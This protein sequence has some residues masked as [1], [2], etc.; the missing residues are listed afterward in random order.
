MTTTVDP[1]TEV[2]APV[3]SSGLST[4]AVVNI[5]TAIA[6]ALFW[7]VSTS[8]HPWNLFARAG[9]S[10]DFYDEQARVFLR[11]RLAVD[12]AVPGPEGFL[13]DGGTY[14]YYGPFLSIVRMPFQ[15]FGDL[16]TARLVRVSMLIA[17]VVSCRWSARLARAA[18]TVVTGEVGSFRPRPQTNRS[19]RPRPQTNRTQVPVKLAGRR[20]R[21]D[22]T[23][24]RWSSLLKHAA[25][26]AV[27]RSMCS[28]IGAVRP[29]YTSDLIS[30]RLCGDPAPI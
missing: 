14:L 27:W 28:P 16:F 30:P 15:L 18:Q 2:E 6:V 12:P 8:W 22:A 19:F 13:I 21:N 29:S 9:F 26:A 23:P 5:V 7:L 1:S 17:V 25:S 4:A 11:G 3:R 20:S 10:A 24:S